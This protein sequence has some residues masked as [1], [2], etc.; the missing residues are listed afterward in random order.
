MQGVLNP[1]RARNEKKE[2]GTNRLPL[3]AIG[4]KER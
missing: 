4:L 3:D 2:A 1:Y